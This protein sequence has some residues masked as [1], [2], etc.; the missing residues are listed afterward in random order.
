[1]SLTITWSIDNLKTLD[2]VSPGFVT[3]VNYSVL[4]TEDFAEA[5]HHG[6]VEFEAP[7]GELIPF[8][9]LTEMQVIQWV[10]GA[11]GEEEL[12]TINNRLRNQLDAQLNPPVAPKSVSLPWVTE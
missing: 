6:Q 5:R 12:Q 2:H 3:Y 4:A 11:L 8:Q 7:S 10:L 9:D 1:M